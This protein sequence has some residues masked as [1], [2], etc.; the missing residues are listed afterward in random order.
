[1]Q[2]KL[3]KKLFS[4]LIFSAEYSRQNSISTYTKYLDEAASDLLLSLFSSIQGMYKPAKLVL[5]CSI[6]NFLKS[7]LSIIDPMIINEKLIFSIFDKAKYDPHF[8]GTIG[9]KVLGSLQ[10]D[11]STL[12]RTVH[13]APSEIHTTSALN[14]LPHYSQQHFSELSSLFIRT[15]ENFLSVLYVNYPVIVD[16]MH[17]ENKADF[18]DCL[19][20]SIKKSVVEQLYG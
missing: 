4:L 20:K 9:S 8:I 10:S 1:M 17:P 7:M 18:L 19:S 3:H 12:C 5:R 14:L 13:S 2:K 11:Y 15:T 6:E 16:R